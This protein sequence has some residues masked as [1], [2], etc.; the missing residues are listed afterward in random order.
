MNMKVTS[1]Q[2]R[3]TNQN[4]WSQTTV[5]QLPEKK[6]GGVRIVKGEGGQIW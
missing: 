6:K 5:W 1:E 2:I 3:K 4:T